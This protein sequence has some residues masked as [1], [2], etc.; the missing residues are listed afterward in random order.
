[1]EPGESGDGSRDYVFKQDVEVHFTGK[2]TLD[3]GL[4]VGRPH[5]TRGADLGRPD[6]RGL[7][8]LQRRL[9]RDPIRTSV[10]PGA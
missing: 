10:R 5:R 7:V 2:T 4:T 3:D 6:R 1:M 8:L 9:R